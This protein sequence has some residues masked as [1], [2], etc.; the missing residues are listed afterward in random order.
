MI[1]QKVY[2]IDPQLFHKPVTAQ[3]ISQSIQKVETITLNFLLNYIGINFIIPQISHV[4][5]VTKRGHNI[6]KTQDTSQYYICARSH[7][8]IPLYYSLEST[9]FLLYRKSNHF[10]KL[11][12]T[13][14]A[15]LCVHREYFTFFVRGLLSEV[16]HCVSLC[17]ET[18]GP[19]LI[20]T[21]HPMRHQV[22]KLKK[23]ITICRIRWQRNHV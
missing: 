22:V 15:R 14:E 11:S 8:C 9:N 4:D 19:P 7:H 16:I 17:I 10:R 6:H 18:F 12:Q 23:D 5:T 2:I 3:V 13:V 20:T 21:L 1:F